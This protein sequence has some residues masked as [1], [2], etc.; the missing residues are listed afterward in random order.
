MTAAIL[1]MTLCLVVAPSQCVQAEQLVTL[2]ECRLDQR[3]TAER[4]A[5]EHEGYMLAGYH[6]RRRTA[7]QENVG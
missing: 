4:I 7:G 5:A 1:T 2:Q 6:C 3:G